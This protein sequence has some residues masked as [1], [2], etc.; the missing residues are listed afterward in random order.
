MII[1]VGKIPIYMPYLSRHRGCQ[2]VPIEVP[3]HSSL[4][5]IIS[6]FI[7]VLSA[8]ALFYFLREE[9]SDF[10]S[11]LLVGILSAIVGALMFVLSLVICS[12]ILALQ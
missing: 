7:G 4:C 5:G 6:I 1:S 12:C 9:V 10:V 3:A 11:A 2:D 8:C